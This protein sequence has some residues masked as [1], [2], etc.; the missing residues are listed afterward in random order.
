MNPSNV[1]KDFFWSLA[2]TFTITIW[3]NQFPARIPFVA[4]LPSPSVRAG[5]LTLITVSFVAAAP[6]DI[7]HPL[8]TSLIPPLH[9]MF[10]RLPSPSLLSRRHGNA[11]PPSCVNKAAL[12]PQ[13][14]APLPDCFPSSIYLLTIYRRACLPTS[15]LPLFPFYPLSVPASVVP[16]LCAQTLPSPEPFSRLY[17]YLPLRTLAFPWPLT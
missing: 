3:R 6:Q 1:K 15:I 4:H 14:A 5:F 17:P 16:C 10:R 7:I 2:F 9:P 11:C 8:T 13:A 12:V